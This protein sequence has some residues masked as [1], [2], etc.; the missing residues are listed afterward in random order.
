MG[1]EM[2]LQVHRSHYCHRHQHL[3]EQGC[4]HAA[5]PQ[6]CNRIPALRGRPLAWAHISAIRFHTTRL[7]RRHKAEAETEAEV[8]AEVKVEAGAKAGA[9][10]GAMSGQ[11]PTAPLQVSSDLASHPPS[12]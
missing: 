9:E 11:A 6:G 4:P 3:Q 2:H 1:T 7:V 12:P 5:P 8:G 10:A